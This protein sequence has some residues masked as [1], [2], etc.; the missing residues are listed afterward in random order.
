M[1]FQ[2]AWKPVGE[3][4]DLKN[5]DIELTDGTP[6]TVIVR[7]GEGNLTFSEKRNY[8]VQLNRG[9]LDGMGIKKGDEAPVEFS[10]DIAWDWIQGTSATPVTGGFESILSIIGRTLDVNGDPVGKSTDGDECNPYAF[11]MTVK[12]NAACG[13]TPNKKDLTFALCR[14]DQLQYDIGGAKLQMTGKSY[15]KDFIPITDGA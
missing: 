6:T 9:K 7:V 4:I 5:C 11:T 10:L 15:D 13:T 3:L 14:Y 12:Y 2:T 1:N 8:D